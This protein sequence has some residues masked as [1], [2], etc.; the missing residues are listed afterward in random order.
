MLDI[1]NLLNPSGIMIYAGA[2]GVSASNFQDPV[3]LILRAEGLGCSKMVVVIAVFRC[4][5]DHSVVPTVW[6][7]PTLLVHLPNVLRYSCFT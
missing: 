3:S 7:L 5:A 6:I 2:S 1:S 4:H